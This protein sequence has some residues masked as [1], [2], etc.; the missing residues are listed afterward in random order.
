MGSAQLVALLVGESA[1]LAGAAGVCREHG[2]PMRHLNAAEGTY[3]WRELEPKLI[4]VCGQSVEAACYLDE[5]QVVS[6]AQGAPVLWIQTGGRHRALAHAAYLGA[7]LG[8]RRIGRLICTLADELVEQSNPLSGRELRARVSALLHA[9]EREGAL[10]SG[11]ANR[12]GSRPANALITPVGAMLG[13]HPGHASD[14]E[15]DW[16][17]SEEVAD[18]DEALGLRRREGSVQEYLAERPT[19][20][21]LK[22][23]ALPSCEEEEWDCALPA[24]K[25]PVVEVEE[26]AAGARPRSG[27]R[28]VGTGYRP[29]R[30]TGR[31]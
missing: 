16:G 31:K 1:L 2:L 19:M 15:W 13:V 12:P 5:V 6:T 20:P 7:G 23:P 11:G 25:T 9:M 24:V 17:Q 28:A 10:H 29:L 3:W 8:P 18:E 14:M 4:V 22:K 30:K 27:P 21:T 26:G